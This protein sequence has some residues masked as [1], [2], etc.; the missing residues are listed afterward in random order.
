MIQYSEAILRAFAS[1]NGVEQRFID[2]EN[3]IQT[4]AG[5]PCLRGG[6]SAGRK[7][8]RQRPAWKM[9]CSR[10]GR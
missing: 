5:R 2:D 4:D 9:I 8:P 10:T 1:H 7:E 3:A 6:A